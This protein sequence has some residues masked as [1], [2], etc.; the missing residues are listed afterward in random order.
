MEFSKVRTESDI[1]RELLALQERICELR[2]RASGRTTRIA[3]DYIQEIF[4]NPDEWTNI[5]DHW[6][7]KRAAKFLT[8]RI[9][10]RLE[11]EHGL[12][13]EV[14]SINKGF[15]IRLKNYKKPDFSE[16]LKQM[17]QQFMQKHIILH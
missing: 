12:E 16:E 2:Y 1:R 7:E 14:K 4:R 3:D 13:T 5:Y 11:A 6:P 17:E 9:R 15:A 8:D 10:R